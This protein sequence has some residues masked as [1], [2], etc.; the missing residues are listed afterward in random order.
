MV[1]GACGDHGGWFVGGE[2]DGGGAGGVHIA[3]RSR[4]WRLPVTGF[5]DPPPATGTAS[6][7]GSGG[8]VALTWA[9]VF[10]AG[11]GVGGGGESS[12][13][14][15]LDHVAINR[16]S[17]ASSV[18][19]GAVSVVDS[20]FANDA[21]G[22]TA[23]GNSVSV[24][25]NSFSEISSGDVIAVSSDNS[26]AVQGNAVT[27]SGS[28]CSFY[29]D[30]ISVNSGALSLAK[31][32]GNSGS[33]NSARPSFRL[34]GKLAGSGS[35]ATLP[36]GWTPI[37][38]LDS[39]SGLEIPT[40]STLTVPAGAV[41]KG[42]GAGI[43]VAGGSL[44]AN[45]TAAAPVVFTSLL[46]P[47]PGGYTITGFGDPA[48]GNW[49]GI[50]VG[51]GG[52]VALTRAKVFYAST[53]VDGGDGS[54]GSV[55]LDHVAID[56][57]NTAAAIHAA[58]VSVVDSS[59]ANDA[60]GVS[61]TGDSVS[62][63]RNSFTQI[64]GGDA[65]SVSSDPTPTVQDNSVTNSGGDC[66]SYCETIAVTS[67]ALNLAK[68]TGNSGS[69]NS[70]RPSFRLSGKLA[71]SGSLA[72]LPAGWTPILGLDSGGGLEIPTGSTLTVPAGAVVKGFG[73]GIRV[74]GGSLVANGTAAAPVVFTSLLDPA[75]GGYTITGFGDPAPGNWNGIA[76]GDGGSLS[77]TGE[78]RYASTAIQVSD[79]GQAT[80]RGKITQSGVGVSSD[81]YVD[82]RSVDWG[83]PSG[84]APSGSGT[85][86]AGSGVDYSPWVGYTPPPN[87]P[88]PSG[89]STP[90]APVAK[91]SCA[92]FIG[93][94]GSGELPQ[95]GDPYDSAPFSGLG[96]KV[97]GVYDAF[98]ARLAARNIQAG[99]PLA[100]DYP[101]A[102]ATRF[103]NY[104]DGVFV[105]SYLRGVYELLSTMKSEAGACGGQRKFVL[106]GYSQGALVI[107][108][109][110][111]LMRNVPGLSTEKILA[112][113][114]IADPA[115]R[116]DGQETHVGS[117]PAGPSARGLYDR[118]VQAG[119]LAT[120]LLTGPGGLVRN[121]LF[122]FARASVAGAP[123]I[124]SGLTGRTLSLC[125]I[126][127]IVCAPGFGA[128]GAVHSTYSGSD[129]TLL[130][131]SAANRVSAP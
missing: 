114:L 68:L 36:A 50:A 13:S 113:E 71:G 81:T 45:G 23:H 96:E 110:L 121:A 86:V 61:A 12:G 15:A 87:P 88:E 129:I 99:T 74:A 65:I 54:S 48:P 34:S 102:S 98:K 78:L 73:A 108:L 49:N 122:G 89:P 124:P 67:Q 115:G 10:Y 63:L 90:S 56:R 25:R 93:V 109:A 26:P 127:D 7:S 27:K 8:R 80:V 21:S 33:D 35:L 3:A 55:T 123:P 85:P 76:V 39:G 19:A 42:F 128:S 1:K 105:Y 107:H 104:I 92:L 47:A 44:V 41:V 117:I 31:L 95:D 4:S 52:R 51:S 40:G 64:S 119:V 30:T 69:N 22:V 70:A 59:F 118:A 6:R 116:G 83:S 126:H 16:S 82:A 72:T 43:R 62:V 66:S 106:V 17:T 46:D 29:C 131:D 103:T 2:R 120:T 100:L 79:G 37:L 24:L 130:G 20:S 94:R 77:F 32:T 101:A 18:N 57:A 91:F 97:G 125:Y 28:D 58:A 60:G 38:G 111:D 75:P 112:V 9:K 11:T 84:P 53:G 14:V 5:R